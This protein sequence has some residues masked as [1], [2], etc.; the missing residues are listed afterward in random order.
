[1]DATVA[2]QWT[3]HLTMPTGSAA[4]LV[5]TLGNIVPSHGATE[6][7]DHPRW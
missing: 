6:A 1:M 7:K 3:V 5:L 2:W 4:G